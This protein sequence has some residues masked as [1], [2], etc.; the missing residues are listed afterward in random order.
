[1]RSRIV[2]GIQLKPTEQA[3]YEFVAGAFDFHVRKEG[4]TWVL[5][6]F[7]IEVADA[8]EAHLRSIDCM[9]LQDAVLYVKEES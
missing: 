7:R 4:R 1:M 3:A 9:S 2:A 6:Q 5:D 8:D